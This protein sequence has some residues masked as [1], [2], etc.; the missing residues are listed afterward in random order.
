MT[1]DMESHV[2]GMLAPLGGVTVHQYDGASIYPGRADVCNLQVDVRASSKKRARDRAY[3]ARD[4]V[5]DLETTDWVGQPLVVL[6]VDT[7]QG[8][9]WLPEPDGAPRYV[10]RVAVRVH[11][12]P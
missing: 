8:P 5:L 2:Y 4:L 6:A 11:P 1:P 10:F 3:T 9:A 7:V 12:Q